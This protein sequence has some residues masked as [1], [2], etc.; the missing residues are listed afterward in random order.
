MKCEAFTFMATTELAQYMQE[1][2]VT[3][4]SNGHYELV[5]MNKDQYIKFRYHFIDKLMY[6]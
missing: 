3:T 4:H 5:K 6:N 1:L 2:K